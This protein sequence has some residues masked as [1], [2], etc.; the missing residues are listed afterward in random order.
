MWAA[1]H[2]RL[3][4]ADKKVVDVAAPL[5]DR[6]VVRDDAGLREAFVRDHLA[7]RGDG[8]LDYWDLSRRPGGGGVVLGTFRF[9]DELLARLG[10]PVESETS[11]RWCSP[12]SLACGAA[13]AGIVH[14]RGGDGINCNVRH[15]F[16][17]VTGCKPRT[18]P[19]VPGNYFGNCVEEEDDD[20]R[21][22]T[23]SAASA[24][25]WHAIEKLAE[26]VRLVRECAA[27]RAVT[28]AGSP[29]LGIY[30]AADLGAGRG[31]W[32]SSPWNGRARWPWP[33]TSTAAA[34][35]RSG[36]RYR[37]GRWRRSARSTVTSRRP[38]VKLTKTARSTDGH[39]RERDTVGGDSERNCRDRSPPFRRGTQHMT[40]WSRRMDAT[41]RAPRGTLL[42]V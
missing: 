35:S 26:Q 25:I 14:A 9:T 28:V 31:R 41:S 7:A 17:F 21:G 29:K 3:V 30:A 32:R 6:G 4:S 38:P 18:I 42:S 12:Y 8:R 11:A 16:G 40:S 33:R 23:A 2:R 19:P 20:G 39:V 13:W 15:Q 36:W 5:F 24:A 1:I 22:L 34:A 10:K 37:A 27:A